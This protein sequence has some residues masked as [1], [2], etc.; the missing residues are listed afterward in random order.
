MPDNTV[1]VGR[2]SKWG[3][4]FVVGKD[5]NAEECITKY[6]HLNFPYL[7]LG[8]LNNMEKFRISETR[9][10]DAIRDLRSKNLACWC[11]LGAHCH[12]DFLLGLVNGR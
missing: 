12:A 11:S 9:L 3:N 8:A 10:E 2:G 7:N 6:I 1:Y 5:G 4:P